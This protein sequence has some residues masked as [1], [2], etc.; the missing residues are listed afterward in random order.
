MK[1]I[2]LIFGIIITAIT[3]FYFLP[4]RIPYIIRTK[5]LVLPK[6]EWSVVRNLNGTFVTTFKDNISGS[7]SSNSVTE[8]ITSTD[9]RFILNPTIQQKEFVNEGDTIGQIISNDEEIKIQTLEDELNVQRATLRYYSTGEKNASVDEA[10]NRVVLAKQELVAQKQIFDRFQSLINDTL[11]TRFEFE[12][13]YNQ[14]KIKE[15]N[16][17]IAEAFYKSVTTGDKPEQSELI[18]SKIKSIENQIRLMK[19]RQNKFT[20]IAPVPG[21][22][23]KKMRLIEDVSFML[24]IADTTGFV[25]Q[26]PIDYYEREFLKTGLERTFNIDNTVQIVSG[27]QAIYVSSLFENINKSL[28][29][30]IVLDAKIYCEPMTPAEYVKRLF[31]KAFY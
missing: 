11:I 9:A 26:L 5:G 7:I 24:E 18:I 19:V 1:K 29:T 14:L 28:V 13:A 8:F 2:Y 12:N 27:K 17:S 16:V 25:A 21:I 10:S 4:V 6:S 30:G 23:V 31:S 20:V 3:I 22:L 15:L